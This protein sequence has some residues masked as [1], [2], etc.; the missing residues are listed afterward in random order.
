[1]DF[2]KRLPQMDDFVI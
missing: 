1:M 2:M